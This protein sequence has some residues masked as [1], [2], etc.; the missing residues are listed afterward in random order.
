MSRVVCIAALMGLGLL[1]CSPQ[2]DLAR[3]GT[4]APVDGGGAAAPTIALVEPTPG[5]VAPRNLA[6]VVLRLPA[7][8]RPPGMVVELRP[9]EGAPLPLGPA[10]VI[11]CTG[12]GVCYAFSAAGPVPPGRYEVAGLGGALFEDGRPVPTAPAGAFSVDPALDD[13]PPAVQTPVVE[14]VGDCLRIRFATDEPARGWLVVSAGG[15]EQVLAAGEGSMAFD[16]ATR[17]RVP[18][19]AAGELVVRAVDW[20]GN[21]GQAAPLPIVVPAP[22]LPLVITEVLPNPRGPETTQEFVEL[23]NLGTAPIVL[24][25]ISIEDA[26]G[27]DPLPPATLGAGAFAVVVAAAY[28]AADGRD[29][30]PRAGSMLLRV[31]G[32]I[33]RDGIGST[34][35]AVRLR[36]RGGEV[37]SRYGGWVDAAP[38]AFSGHSVQRQPQEACDGPAAW[39]PR[40]QTPTPGW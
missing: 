39:N 11:E 33:G 31:A 15:A 32:R 1:A 9:S 2:T 26:G 16:V 28:D 10:I 40:P 37:L 25:G 3:A 36:G 34:G 23:R 4:P 12:G 27:A 6:A 8:L 21:L 24:D 14:T 22:A 29:P 35:E 5:A 20:A 17:L 38:T 13:T 30:A 19:G 18:P 7:A